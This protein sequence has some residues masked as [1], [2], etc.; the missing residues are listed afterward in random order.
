MLDTCVLLINILNIDNFNSITDKK[1]CNIQ[2]LQPLNLFVGFGEKT[3]FNG[4]DT[5]ENVVQL[6]IT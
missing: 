2:T 6:F 3:R 1:G 4:N 5:F